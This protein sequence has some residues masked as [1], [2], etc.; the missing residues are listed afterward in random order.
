MSEHRGRDHAPA[1]LVKA[2]L[3]QP[4]RLETVTVL[5]NPSSY[6]IHRRQRL[7]A[8]ALA[9][10]AAAAPGARPLAGG[11]R[12]EWFE[13]ELFVDTTERQGAERDARAIVERLAGWMSCAAPAGRPLEVVFNWGPFRFAGA[14]ESIEEEWVRFDADGT[15]VRAWV[16]LVLR[17]AWT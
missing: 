5:W 9:P 10:P 13:T 12:E 16:T 6:R 2:I 8:P 15:P 7:R 4:D 17:R 3:V 11:G 14:V 1:R